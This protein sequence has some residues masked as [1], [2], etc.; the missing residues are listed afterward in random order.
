LVL[1]DTFLHFTRSFACSCHS[2]TSVLSPTAIHALRLR[3][4]AQDPPSWCFALSDSPT[5]GR[6]GISIGGG[7]LNP[8][9]PVA[10]VRQ[11]G[12]RGGVV[13]GG[14]RREGGRAGG[15]EVK[16]GREGR[17]GRREMGKKSI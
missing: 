7:A 9:T 13:E 6:C 17:R 11:K 5:V 1:S 8:I 14:R 15:K 4:T 3:C 10:I 2:G 16:R 12:R